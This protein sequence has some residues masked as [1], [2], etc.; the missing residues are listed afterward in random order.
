MDELDEL[1]L[2]TLSFLEPMSTERLILDFDSDRLQQFPDF[3]KETLEKKLK[4]LIKQK[5]V[6]VIKGQEPTY[7]KLMPKRPWWK[8]I[9]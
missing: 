2:E 5:K 4:S 9:F 1:I 3:N 7:L 6:K 8:K